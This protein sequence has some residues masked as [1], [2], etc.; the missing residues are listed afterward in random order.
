MKKKLIIALL[1]FGSTWN[2]FSQRVS[3][4]IGT[5][6]T[7]IAPSAVVEIES[8]TKGF[9]P[10]RMT[11]LERNAINSPAT[12]LI[13]YCIN[14]GSNGELQVF[15]GSTWTNVS[16]SSASVTM[17]TNVPTSNG[18]TLVFMAHNLGADESADPLE[19]SWRINGAYFQWGRKPV[20]TNRD[21]YNT[22]PNNGPEGF[23]AAPTGPGASEANDGTVANW[24]NTPAADGAWNLTEGSPVKTSND[25]CPNG[26]RVPTRN[27]WASIYSTTPVN[28]QTNWSNV[29]TY[30]D[31]P[32]NYTAGKKVNNSL[33]LP[34]SG[35]R[36]PSDGS[37]SFH[38]FSGHY[39][40]S[41]LGEPGAYFGLRFDSS[42]E[43][44]P[45]SYSN[46]FRGF[47][48]RCVAE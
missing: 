12:G 46:P 2:V 35:Y 34:A 15:N 20:D 4:K 45:A 26:F 33:Y 41:T 13:V 32:T 36:D 1:V 7:S 6:P 43:V 10:P 28:T 5:N 25:P 37:L 44:N 30:S 9:L 31:S 22:K 27:E 29:G 39:W 14:C 47:S 18:G 17:T 11:F 16:G 42:S 23:A 38:G 3:Q 21:K 24:S 19:P 48:V 8:T 40:T